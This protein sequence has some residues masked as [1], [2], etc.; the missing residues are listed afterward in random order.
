MGIEAGEHSVERLV[1]EAVV[2]EFVEVW[3][4]GFGGL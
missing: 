2:G 1:D 3:V 4:V